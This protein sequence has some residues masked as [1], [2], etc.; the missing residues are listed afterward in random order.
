VRGYVVECYVSK[1]HT[2]ELSDVIARARAAARAMTREGIPVR[3]LRSIL[4]PEDETC[5][6]VFEGPSA[7]AVGEASQRAAI[8]YERIAE[9]VQ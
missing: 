5:F 2:G 3:Y 1:A 7:K 9:A 4:V 8:A 6:H